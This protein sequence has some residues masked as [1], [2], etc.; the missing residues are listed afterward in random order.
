MVDIEGSA[1]LV[2]WN[3][4]VVVLIDFS[5]LR[6]TT[7]NT[8]TD[9]SFTIVRE[10]GHWRVVALTYYLAGA[11]PAM[12]FSTFRLASACFDLGGLRLLPGMALIEP[13]VSATGSTGFFLGI[14]SLALIHL[15]IQNE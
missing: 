11:P 5:V 7:I 6:R 1:G 12:I 13:S 3:R 9:D 8:H 10:G 4:T 15:F 2:L 14:I